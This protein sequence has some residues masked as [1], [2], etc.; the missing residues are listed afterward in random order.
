MRKHHL[1]LPLVLAALVGAAACGGDEGSME[2][3][4]ES[5]QSTE[6]SP[7]TSGGPIK[8][9]MGAGISDTVGTQ[10]VAPA[11]VTPS[12]TATAPGGT[13]PGGTAPR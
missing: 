2:E 5:V 8:N 1:L 4:E 9:G 6:L 11:I 12:D 10:P 13:T 7:D 3:L